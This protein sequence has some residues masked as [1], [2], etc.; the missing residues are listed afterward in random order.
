MAERTTRRRTKISVTVDPRLLRAV[1]AY[2]E[3][4]SDLDRSKVIDEALQ[5]WLAWRQ[6][7]AMRAQFEGPD[8]VEGTAE[9]DAWRRI[10]REA[11]R[12]MVARGEG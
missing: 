8:E 1:D 3:E 4:H 12:R 9:Y 5:N 11:A 7:E 6:E 10:R 2:V